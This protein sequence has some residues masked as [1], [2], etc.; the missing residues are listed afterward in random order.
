MGAFSKF[1]NIGQKN[2]DIILKT[3]PLFS[4]IVLMSPLPCCNFKFRIFEI[5]AAYYPAW[6]TLDSALKWK[7]MSPLNSILVI[8]G[9]MASHVSDESIRLIKC[10]YLISRLV[11]TGL[12]I[13]METYAASRNSKGIDE[14]HPI[15][16]YYESIQLIECTYIILD[17]ALKWKFMLP[18][19]SIFENSCKWN[20]S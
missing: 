5:Y 3:V 7:F 2:P 12:C 9:L 15:F 11:D 6:L 13:K 16:C 1:E 14:T 18:L 4:K 17:F 19:D 10:M 8:S 20:S